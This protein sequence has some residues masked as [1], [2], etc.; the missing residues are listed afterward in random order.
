MSPKSRWLI[1]VGIS[2]L[3]IA[4]LMQAPQIIHMLQPEYKGIFVH[5][6]SDED[7]YLARVEEA[8]SGRPELASEAF[9]GDPDLAG[10]QFAFIER[11]Y[12]YLF[13]WTGMRA[14][15][16]LQI[17]DSVIPVLVFLLLTVFLQLCGFT[18]L[19]AFAGSA[20]FVLVELYGLNRPINM[21]DSFAL[22]LIALIVILVSWRKISISFGILGGILLGTLVGVYFWS[23]SFAWLWWGIFLLWEFFESFI[24]QKST[25]WKLVLMIGIIGIVSALPAVWD[26]AILM[27][28]PL[29]EYGLIRS[30]MRFGRMPESAVYSVLFLTLG[31]LASAKIN[32]AK[33]SK[34]KPAIITV[35]SAVLFIHQQVVHGVTFVFV[36]HS[37]FSLLLGAICVL[38]LAWEYKTKWLLLS[39]AA[40]GV[41]IA[42]LAYDGRY[43]LKQWIP[44]TSNFSEQHLASA[45]PALDKLERARILSDT[46]SSSFIAGYT[47][48]D[49]VYSIHLKNT[50]MTHGELAERF[51]MTQIAVPPGQRNWEERRHLVHPESSDK[52]IKAWEKSLVSSACERVDA[53]PEAYLRKFKVDY[54]FWDEKRQPSWQIS[55]LG[56]FL[57]LV[58]RGEG[59]AI[60]KIGY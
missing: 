39:A 38:L 57:K 50:L 19:Q 59:W 42:G 12:G 16:V 51:C 30:G 15:V 54:V 52:K 14:A 49:I 7:L 6:N 45:L 41:Y 33:L 23:W 47:R 43:V 3:V 31:V 36:S 60:Y 35:L 28:N 9:T 11:M 20:L 34:H 5:M 53:S 55:R 13:G 29:Y 40:A 48:H 8:L 56:M 24:R 44:E 46:S 32:Y 18:C 22:M 4:V 10:T 2:S 1:I 37:I 27:K 21:R 17:M 58:E 25:N 26:M